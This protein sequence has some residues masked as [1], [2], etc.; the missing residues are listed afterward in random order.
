MYNQ[1]AADAQFPNA[2]QAA[3]TDAPKDHDC[4]ALSQDSDRQELSLVSSTDNPSSGGSAGRLEDSFG[5]DDDDAD[6]G[7]AGGCSPDERYTQID[8][9]GS[10]VYGTVFLV[11]DRGTGETLA[12]KRLHLDDD[13]DG[14]VPA[15]VIREV[16]LLRDF[17]H[18]N[19]VQIRSVET[20]GP[21]DFRLFFEYVPTD[22]YQVLRGHRR[23][24]SLLPM[25]LVRQ[26]WQELLSGIHACH[27]RLILH[28]DLK[29]QNLLIHP[30]DGLKI[31]DFGLAR[32]F[33]SPKKPYTKEVVTLWYRCPE[34]LLGDQEY[35]V[36][37]DMWSAGCILAEIATCQPLFPGDS[38]IG[39]LFKILQL[40]GSPTETTW[41]GLEGTLPF[42][43]KN[44][45]KWPPTG[46]R[47]VH[48]RRPE[49]GQA[50]MDLLRSLLVMNPNVRLRSR[51]AQKHPFFSNA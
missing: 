11:K 50:G 21:K 6:A 27:V 42:W 43:S 4:Q 13:Q 47:A 8:V 39:T 19:V 25:H 51:R 22:L 32:T 28:R 33:S 37:V 5:D 29:P 30:T 2:D 23:E 26:Y 36:E 18:P 15:H 34:L 1:E 48:D 20:S 10:G 7:W 16:S 24:G 12:M 49:L 9:L 17:V 40:L 35:G 44:F 41:P 3:A 31:C 46:L 45:P 38:E 14:G